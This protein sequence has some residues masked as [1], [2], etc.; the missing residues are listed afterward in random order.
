MCTREERVVPTEARGAQDP[1]IRSGIKRADGAFL[2]SAPTTRSLSLPQPHFPS[3]SAHTFLSSFNKPLPAQGGSVSV[4]PK[5][6]ADHDAQA[7]NINKRQTNVWGWRASLEKFPFDPPS[8]YVGVRPIAVWG[9]LPST[10]SL[11]LTARGLSITI[12]LTPFV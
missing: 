10:F 12:L 9:V 11:I 1:C 4:F 8:P 3:E 7:T 2:L 5:A 6:P